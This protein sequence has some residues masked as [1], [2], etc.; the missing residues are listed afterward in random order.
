MSIVPGSRWQSNSFCPTKKT[1]ENNV[2]SKNVN[3][4][5]KTASLSNC[6]NCNISSLRYGNVE[7][8]VLLLFKTELTEIW[9]SFNCSSWS[10]NHILLFFSGWKLYEFTCNFIALDKWAMVHTRTVRLCLGW[11]LSG[12]G[13][14]IQAKWTFQHTINR[15]SSFPSSA[16]L[17]RS[18]YIIKTSNKMENGHSAKFSSTKCCIAATKLNR[19]RMWLHPN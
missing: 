14:T 17:F 10:E 19:S 4:T 18:L 12:N 1:R 5:E 11:K 7:S 16:S 9:S 15:T 6:V 13:C 3:E 2:Y 8:W